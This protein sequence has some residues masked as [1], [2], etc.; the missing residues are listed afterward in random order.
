MD[1]LEK[2][3]SIA[4][5]DRPLF[6]DKLKEICDNGSYSYD[7]IEEAGTKDGNKA[8]IIEKNN[9]KYRLNSIYHPL[10]EVQ[11]WADQYDFQ[12]LNISVMMFGM[13]NGLFVQE[14]LKRLQ[15]DATVYLYEPDISVFLYDLNNVDITDILDDPRVNLMVEGI[16][17]NEFDVF[18]QNHIDWRMLLSQIICHHPIYDKIYGD[19]Y[20]AFLK[21]IYK[22]NNLEKIN[23]DTEKYMSVA[24]AKNAVINLR[25]IQKS[26][27]ISEF[28]GKMP[29]EFPAVIVAAGPSLDKNIDELKNAEGKAFI[30]ATDTSVKYLIKHDIRF[31]AMI[32]I[33]S[34]KALWH[35]KNEKCHNVPMFC[36][37]DTSNRF[38]EMHTGRKIWFR[39]SVYMYG[40]YK[41]FNHIFPEYNSGGSVAT[42]AFSA[43]VSLG[44]KNIVLIGQDLAYSG[45]ITHAGGNIKK[46]SNEQYGKK[47]VDSIDGGKVWSRYDWLIYLEWFEDAIKAIKGINVIDATEGGALIHG[48]RVMKL[49]EVIDEYCKEEFSFKELLDSMPYTFTDEEYKIVR[50]N[51]IGIRKEFDNMERKA[52]EGIK[53]ADNLV[54]IVNS[55]KHNTKSEHNNLKKIDKI[56]K[57]IGTQD[58]YDILDAYV[59]SAIADDI[60]KINTLSKDEDENMKKTLE[61]SVALYN[62]LIK[63]VETL[64]PP[65]E[66]TIEVIQR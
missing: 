9:T 22:V 61:I 42:A 21:K 58:A 66:E 10:S 49:S 53:V 17:G 54:K 8:L 1:F 59:T 43:C 27:Y 3:L 16:N 14:M 12:N 11:R 39:G 19:K 31:D 6:Y 28:I 13:G 29:E 2:N 60:Q 15:Q 64:M 35:L 41:K 34:K 20:V 48:T 36:A 50:D 51:I 44:F 26:N 7:N 40:L 62:A 25:Y 32:T 24:L 33:D 46:I 55:G 52:R 18:L 4:K 65:L 38:M 37:L 47:L 23:M 5:K 63:A 56:N 57:F 30:F 45:D